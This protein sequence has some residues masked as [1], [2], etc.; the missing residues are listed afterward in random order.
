MN[1]KIINNH[2]G[3]LSR[4][5]SPVACS[6]VGSQGAEI[7]AREDSKRE[8]REFQGG[9]ADRDLAAGSESRVS[10]TSGRS[11]KAWCVRVIETSF[12][13]PTV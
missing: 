3:F 7:S 2:S 12:A 8:V 1:D 5:G 10:K 4:L 9:A 6:F 11:F 13:Y